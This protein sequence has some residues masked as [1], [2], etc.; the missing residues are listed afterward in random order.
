M[1]ERFIRWQRKFVFILCE[2]KFF[3]LIFWFS[4]IYQQSLAN[5][6][7]RPKLSIDHDFSTFFRNQHYLKNKHALFAT[8]R[9]NFRKYKILLKKVPKL[10]RLLLESNIYRN[11]NQ[12]YE[13]GDP[14]F[15]KK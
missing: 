11:G 14:I 6:L 4:N 1:G 15:L 2:E 3:F 5:S 12:R 13:R 9:K 7:A 8:I 10:S